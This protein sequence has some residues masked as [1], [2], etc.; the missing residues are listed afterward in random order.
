MTRDEATR[1]LRRHTDALHRR[2]VASLAIFGTTARDEAGPD[3]DVDILVDLD[4][5]SR[6]SLIEFIGL[7]DYLADLL[8]TKVDLVTRKGLHPD[9]APQILRE[10]VK[11]F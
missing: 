8:S 6:I 9:L 10:A 1:I 7:E 11:V 3:S 4:P 2:G 5:Q